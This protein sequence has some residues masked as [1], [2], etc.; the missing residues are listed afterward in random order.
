M[1]ANYAFKILYE[2]MRLSFATNMTLLQLIELH[3]IIEMVK[4]FQK[5]CKSSAVS[6]QNQ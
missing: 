4:N 2:F 3:R 1:H 6:Q 5:D